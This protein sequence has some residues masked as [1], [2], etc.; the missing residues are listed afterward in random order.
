MPGTGVVSAKVSLQKDSVIIEPKGRVS[1]FAALKRRMSIPLACIKAVST[2]EVP[3]SK[4]YRSIRVGG[5]ALPPHF[6]GRFYSL[7]DG[8]IFCALGDRA[9][10]VT[11]K[12]EGFRYKEV[13]VQVDDKDRTA[14]IIKK[15]LSAI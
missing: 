9:K 12:L 7:D 5:T 6:A 15:A 8:L 2:A 3:K 14:E 10:C 11:L 4:I 1:K 13:I